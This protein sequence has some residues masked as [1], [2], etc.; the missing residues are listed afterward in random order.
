MSL[1][2]DIIRAIRADG[3]RIN[4]AIREVVEDLIEV[5][6][7]ENDETDEDMDDAYDDD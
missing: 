1:E 7:H 3:Y 5:V 6:E 4:S 2:D